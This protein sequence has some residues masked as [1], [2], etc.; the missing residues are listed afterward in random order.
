MSEFVVYRGEFLAGTVRA[1]LTCSDRGACIKWDPQEPTEL[2]ELK[3]QRTREAFEAEYHAWRESC[4]TD[5]AQRIGRTL[6]DSA[7]DDAEKKD[8]PESKGELHP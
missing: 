1:V 5:Y 3:E 6:S 4:A 8:A 7:D 2:K